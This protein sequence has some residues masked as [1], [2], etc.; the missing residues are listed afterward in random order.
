MQSA[1]VLTSQD[2]V[3]MERVLPVLAEVRSIRS[4]IKGLK[5]EPVPV[6]KINIVPGANHCDFGKHTGFPSFYYIR[7]EDAEYGRPYV[8]DTFEHMAKVVLGE[9][10]LQFRAD[11]SNTPETLREKAEALQK[12]LEDPEVQRKIREIYMQSKK[13]KKD[14]LGH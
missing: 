11:C 13:L 1:E 6:V 14:L 5:E 3:T 4:D 9:N 2:P 10:S 7:S 12:K 8:E